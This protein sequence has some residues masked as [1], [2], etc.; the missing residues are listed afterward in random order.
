MEREAGDI[1]KGGC[2]MNKKGDYL[3]LLKIYL[4][5]HDIK[6]EDCPEC[7]I[8]GVSALI[9]DNIVWT[10]VKDTAIEEDYPPGFP[11]G[12]INEIEHDILIKTVKEAAF[13]FSSPYYSRT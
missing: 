12:I 13:Y 6:L 5:G 3:N 7:K 8:K 9:I 4:P 2:R 10:V 11:I 1:G